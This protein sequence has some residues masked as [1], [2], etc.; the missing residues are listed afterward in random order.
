MRPERLFCD[1]SPEAL[2][3]FEAIKCTTAYPKGAVLFVEGQMPSAVFVLCKG[4]VKMSV[5]AGD[6]KVLLVRIAEPGEVLGLSATV[7]GQPY[8]LSAETLETCQVISVERHDLLCFL[9]D[10]PE[11]CLKVV[12][13]L[14][15][16][17]R[18][19][20]E[21]VRSLGLSRTADQR[22]AKFLLEWSKKNGE[23]SDS[24]QH[25]ELTLTQEEIGQLIGNSRETVIRTLSNL[26]KLGIL[27]G[28]GSMLV[29]RDRSRLKEIAGLTDP[30]RELTEMWQ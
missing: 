30:S 11:A 23:V 9:R 10:H 7:S 6:G 14:S 4:R 20:C 24:E 5:C 2:Q 27:E 12:E 15:E 18:T 13:Q 22:L 16:K 8:E 28:H 25:L 21:E 19:A 26:K 29:I 3:A 17:Y 1:F